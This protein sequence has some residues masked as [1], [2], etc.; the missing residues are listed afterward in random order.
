MLVLTN[1]CCIFL[2]QIFC[3]LKAAP[4]SYRMY[5]MTSRKYTKYKIENKKGISNMLENK[6]IE[7]CAPT[8]AALKSANLF[9]YFFTSKEI[10]LSELSELNKKLNFRGVFVEALLWKENSV[11]IY[12]YRKSKLAH[13]LDQLEAKTL[14]K[15][16]GYRGDSMEAC[17]AHLKERLFHY[18]CFPHEIGIFLGYP[19]A[20][21]LGF[22]KYQGKHCK[23]CGLWKVYGNESE[24]KQLFSRLEHCTCV[25]RKVFQTGRSI[26]QMTVKA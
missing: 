24:A 13:D 26:T 1:F 3:V 10:V 14:M 4:C 21:V 15:Q 25:Y 7:Y 17:L 2:Y 8:L 23:C 22:I 9:H 19:L 12:T 5:K 18:D 16:Y 11:L 6:I 20:D